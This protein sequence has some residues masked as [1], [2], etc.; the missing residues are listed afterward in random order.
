MTFGELSEEATDKR[1]YAKYKAA[2]IHNCLKNGETP[3]PGPPGESDE[4]NENASDADAL[5]PNNNQFDAPA[6]TPPNDPSP[7]YNDPSPP[8]NN[9]SFNLPTDSQPFFQITGNSHEMKLTKNS[10][11]I[12]CIFV[13]CH[14]KKNRFHS[15]DKLPSPPVDPDEGNPGG[16]QPYNPNEAPA[17]IVPKYEPPPANVQLT[18]DQMAKAQKYCKYASSAL[19]FDDVKSAMDNLERALHLLATGREKQ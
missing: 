9:P 3:I 1:K 6:P 2:Y 5:P 15:A 14:Q 12:Y 18:A 7:S 16:F 17:A 10:H 13:C 8:N 19:N 4:N 11:D